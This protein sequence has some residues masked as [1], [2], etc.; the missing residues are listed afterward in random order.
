MNGPYLFRGGVYRGSHPETQADYNALK[1]EGVK[2]ILDLEAGPDNDE[3]GLAQLNG[4]RRIVVNMSAF[5]PPSDENVAVALVYLD[6]ANLHPI[7]VHCIKGVDRTGF[8]LA[9]YSMRNG[10]SKKKASAEMAQWGNSWWLSWW[11]LFL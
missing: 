11:R 6:D 8:V 7:Y 2:T 9:R 10:M 3:E 5:V 4:I 1:G